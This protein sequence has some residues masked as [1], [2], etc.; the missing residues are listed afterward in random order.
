MANKIEQLATNTAEITRLTAEL[1][2]QANHRADI[3]EATEQAVMDY[4]VVT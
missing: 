2:I 1:N 3:A 4:M